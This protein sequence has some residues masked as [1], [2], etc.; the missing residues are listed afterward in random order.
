M[1]P[2]SSHLTSSSRQPPR[3]SPMAQYRSSSPLRPQEPPR[4]TGMT[5]GSDV[6]EFESA[7]EPIPLSELEEA[8]CASRA[9]LTG[10][11][12]GDLDPRGMARSQQWTTRTWP[13]SC[14]T[15]APSLLRTTTAPHARHVQ[16]ARA[17]E[18][19]TLSARTRRHRPRRSSRCTG[20]RKPE[21]RPRTASHHP[22][23]LFDFNQWNANKP[24]TTL[25]VPVT[26]T[27]IE[28]IN[29]LFIYLAR[30]YGF[31]IVDEQNGRSAA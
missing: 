5:V 17:G 12:L 15:T 11:N 8:P 29:L 4:R 22:P 28:Y 1:N 9:P 30:S 31:S 21:P 10:L 27:T 6:I 16:P 19:A 25:F 26:N 24:G 14:P 2:T 23:G 13:S 7:Y 18:V 3:G 20:A